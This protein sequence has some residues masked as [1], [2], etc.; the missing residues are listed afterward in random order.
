MVRRIPRGR[1]TTYGTVARLAG[2]P[3]GARQVG[4]AL[5]ALPA[6]TAVPWQ[7]VLNARGG[8]SPRSVPGAEA[9]QRL[10]LELEGVVFGP[11]GL[12]SLARFGWPERA[13]LGTASVS[14]SDGFK[15]K[16]TRR[17][18]KRRSAVAPR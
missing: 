3:G 8:I 12:V 5:S 15:R 1:V 14:R 16:G 4:Y 2:V 11:R 7:R 13:G 10:L 17:D 18:G 6:A 9:A